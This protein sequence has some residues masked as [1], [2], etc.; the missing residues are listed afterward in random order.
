MLGSYAAHDHR[1][2]VDQAKKACIRIP[3][4]SVRNGVCRVHDDRIRRFAA[5][6]FRGRNAERHEFS[7][8]KEVI[9]P[10]VLLRLPCYDFT[11]IM[12]YTLDSCP[13]AVGSPASSATHFRDVTGGVYKARER[14]HRGILIR[15]Y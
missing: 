1:A 14:I 7:F 6:R 15:D 5:V 4:R 11:P 8:R 10:Q 12:N 3:A 9:Q 13:L 2:N